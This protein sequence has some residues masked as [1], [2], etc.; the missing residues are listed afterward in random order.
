METPKKYKLPI[1][2]YIFIPVSILTIIGLSILVIILSVPEATPSDRIYEFPEEI[3][4]THNKVLYKELTLIRKKIN[5]YNEYTANVVFDEVSRVEHKVT[6]LGDVALG[7]EITTDTVLGYDFKNNEVKSSINGIILFVEN[8]TEE[9]SYIITCFD[10]QSYHVI[11]DIPQYDYYKYDFNYKSQFEYVLQ[12]NEAVPLS[13]S[14]IEY[15]VVNDHISVKFL[16]SEIDYSI[17]PGATITVRYKT[18]IDECDVFVYAGDFIGNQYNPYNGE[19]SYF[20]C[21]IETS[22][23]YTEIKVRFGRQIDTLVGIYLDDINIEK[24]LVRVR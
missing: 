21:L 8:K 17:M 3:V 24:I 22:D 7:D 10:S 15:E 14:E 4:E 12:S 23:G 1:F 18:G 2:Y 20:S 13:I 16:P 19:N 6:K 5:T 9:S 11:A